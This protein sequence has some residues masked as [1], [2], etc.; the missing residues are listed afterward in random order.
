M[1][2]FE[3]LGTRFR[4]LFQ[5]ALIK[6]FDLPED[7]GVVGHPPELLTILK[8]A[9]DGSQQGHSPEEPRYVVYPDPPLGD[10]ELQLLED[11][12]PNI[13]FVT[14]TMLPLVQHLIN[15]NSR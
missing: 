1:T 3:V 7:T 12:A 2:L 5:R 13:H 15:R 9:S 4:E 8:I 14:P 11:M 10:E 6:T